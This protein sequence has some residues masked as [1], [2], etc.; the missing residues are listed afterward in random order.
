ME[1]M[2]DDMLEISRLE[3]KHLAFEY[4]LVPFSDFFARL[5]RKNQL[6]MLEQGFVY[7]WIPL[8]ESVSAEHVAAIY[9]DPM[10]VEQVFANLL[11]NARKFTPAGGTIQVEAVVHKEGTPEQ[12]VII[13]FSDT[14]CGI[15]PEEQAHIFERYYRGQ[16]SKAA[17]ASGTGLG[18]P[19]CQ[20]IMNAHQ[21]DVGLEHSSNLGSKFYIRFPLLLVPAH[22]LESESEE[23]A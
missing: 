18:L 3:N 13:R 4:E 19:I 8:S 23:S 15:P 12:S 22:E 9:A 17:T 16:A 20:K 21:G 5:C 1:R 11:S 2:I 10:R 14:G 6:D 7:K